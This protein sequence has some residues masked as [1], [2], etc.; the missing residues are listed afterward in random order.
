M[1]S[2]FYL[3]LSTIS[4]GAAAQPTLVD[5]VN[6]RRHK[7][8]KTGLGVLGGWS[9]ASIGGGLVGAANSTGAVRQ[10]H[11]RNVL[12]GGINL[13]L[14]GVGYLF[15]SRQSIGGNLAQTLSRQE[16][17]EKLYLLNTG[18]DAAYVV[19]GFYYKERA[20]R[21]TGEKRDKRIGTGNSLLLQGGFLFLYDGLLYLLH[22]ANGNRLNAT[23][24]NFTVGATADG[25]GVAYRF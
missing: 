16:R 19:L 15:A 4:F 14:A 24:R 7:L 1:K 21:F 8:E 23:L 9:V 17:I 22:N 25:F 20:A 2:I 13:G 12:F 5:S 3:L 18:L 11:K 6:I 10:F